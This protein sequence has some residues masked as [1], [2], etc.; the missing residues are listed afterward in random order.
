M[1]FTIKSLGENILSETSIFLAD[2]ISNQLKTG[3]NVLFFVTG[4]SAIAVASEVSKI[5]SKSPHQN[6]TIMLTDERYGPLGHPDSNWSQL[7]AK[8]FDLP[9]ARLIPILDGGDCISTTQKF[10]EILKKEVAENS[11]KIGLFGIGADGHTG[12]ILPHSDAV[13]S[14]GLAYTYKT[15]KFERITVTPKTITQLDEIV[16]FVK[17]E[18]KWNTLK[19]L[20]GDKEVFDQPAQI[21]KKVKLLTVFTDY[22]SKNI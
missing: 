14:P 20:E 1:S 6:L 22:K 17:G 16:V 5:L 13:N 2:A 15:E 18:E 4:G 7:L 11:Y 9:Q 12:G 3:K 21:L 10:N 8:G 19:D